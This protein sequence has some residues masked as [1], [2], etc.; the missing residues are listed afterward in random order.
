M[1]RQELSEFSRALTFLDTRQRAYVEQRLRGLSHSASM[2][3]AGYAAVAR[4]IDQEVPAVAMA[5][6]AGMKASARKMLFSRDDAHE[7]LMTAYHSA[8]SAGE[9]VSAV[10][11]LVKLHGI[12]EPAEV[13]HTHVHEHDYRVMTDAELIQ[14]AQQEPFALPAGEGDG[15]GTPEGAA[16]E[17]GAGDEGGWGPG[18]PGE[19]QAV[20]EAE[21]AGAAEA[22]DDD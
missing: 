12:A 17:A 18:E 4:R 22:G 14:L 1:P 2:A 20:G 16:D 15:G 7:M 10:K 8:E 19:V 11:E 5:L 13:R 6:E 3:A 21:A 9:M